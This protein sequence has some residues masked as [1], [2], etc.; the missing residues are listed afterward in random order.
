MT[1]RWTT[2]TQQG[3]PNNHEHFTSLLLP[4]LQMADADVMLVMLG[5]FRSYS[6][7]LV[8]VVVVS[9]INSTINFI[10]RQ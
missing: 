6:E 9:G 1:M 7:A 8:A 2:S 4:G 10:Q 3:G 5:P